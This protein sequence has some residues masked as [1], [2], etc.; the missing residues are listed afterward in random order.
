MVMR[1]QG[2]WQLD[3]WSPVFCSSRALPPLA[4]VCIEWAGLTLLIAK[5]GWLCGYNDKSEG[6]GPRD[7]GV[8]KF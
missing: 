5:R 2:R 7:E 6:S 3:F 4:S 1:T 8:S